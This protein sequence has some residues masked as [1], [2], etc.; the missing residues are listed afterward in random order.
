MF[1]NII[2]R[3]RVLAVRGEAEEQEQCGGESS[4]KYI[5]FLIAI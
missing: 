2:F 5:T 1:H 3:A 4:K